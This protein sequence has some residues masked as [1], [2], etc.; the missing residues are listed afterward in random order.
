MRGLYRPSR[1]QQ[2]IAVLTFD[3]LRVLSACSHSTL[4]IILFPL[5]QCTILCNTFKFN[6]QSALYDISPG[7]R[8]IVSISAYVFTRSFYH[9]ITPIIDVTASQAQAP[10]GRL[11]EHSTI[12]ARLHFARLATTSLTTPD[13][14]SHLA[15]HIVLQWTNCPIALSAT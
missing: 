15:S 5:P 13:D 11:P 14:S 9:S 8:R 1:L 4:R 10:Q 2:R 7:S 6:D 12:K 3:K